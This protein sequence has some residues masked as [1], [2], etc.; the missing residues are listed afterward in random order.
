MINNRSNKFIIEKKKKIKQ[1]L[2]FR[3]E[4]RKIGNG[5]NEASILNEFYTKCYVYIQSL[6]RLIKR[7][8]KQ[9]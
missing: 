1:N 2:L 4:M 7:K 6:T 5:G 8:L 9:K 3:S